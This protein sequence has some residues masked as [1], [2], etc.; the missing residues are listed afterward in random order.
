MTAIETAMTI[1]LALLAGNQRLAR[2]AYSS[3]LA[4]APTE[5][6]YLRRIKR[7]GTILDWMGIGVP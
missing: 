4:D 3:Y 1:D 6:G 2:E 7:L 5:E